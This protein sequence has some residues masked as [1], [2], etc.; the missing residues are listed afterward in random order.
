MA[1]LSNQ[2]LKPVYTTRESWHRPVE[3]TLER[4]HEYYYWATENAVVKTVR[5]AQADLRYELLALKAEDVD[6]LVGELV[7]C[8]SE[9]A[10]MAAA[11]TLLSSMGDNELVAVLAEVF[12][13]RRT[14]NAA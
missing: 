8:A 5:L 13:A 12:T 4:N 2:W 1:F 3:V 14:E 7:A 9:Q 10:R 6:F 11:I